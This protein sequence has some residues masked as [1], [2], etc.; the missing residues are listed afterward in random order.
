MATIELVLELVQIAIHSLLVV[1]AMHWQVI[2][3]ALY[4]LPSTPK[5]I[6]MERKRL[7]KFNF[8]LIFAFTA[9]FQRPDTLSVRFY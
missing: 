7:V 2:L 6:E 8:L 1:R 4:S 3:L 5:R 9:F